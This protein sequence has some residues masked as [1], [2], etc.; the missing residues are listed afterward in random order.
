[1]R[2]CR[3][4][5]FYSTPATP[6][7]VDR[8]VAALVRELGGLPQGLQPRT[9][10][11]GGGTPS[12]L[13]PTHWNRIWE[14]LR[15]RRLLNAAEWTV[16][17]N[18]ATLSL[19]RARLL[20]SL[21]VNRVSL[22]AQSFDPSL[23][24]RLGRIHTRD[25]IFAS[26]DLLR[27]AGFENVNL[28]L[29]FA[30][31]GQ[32]RAAW[33]ATL[34]EAIALQPEHLSAY[35]VIYEENTPLSAQLAAGT[36][37]VDEDL[38]CD[39]YD[40]LLV[41]A[42]RHGFEQYEIANFAKRQAGDEA[43]EVPRRACAH[44]VNYWRGGPF[45]GLGPSATSYLDGVRTRNVADTVRYCERC[46]QGQSA[47]ESS[48]HLPP[49]A[50]AGETAAFG[51]RM[52]AGWPFAEFEQ[53][54]GFDLRDEWH[55]EIQELVGKDWGELRPDRFRLTRQGLRFADAAATLFLRPA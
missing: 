35:E 18:P 7:L 6:E 39:L 10:F 16:E 23:L 51:L 36:L 5:A 30:I 2:K 46:E 15:R 52:T 42:D 3:Y 12:L 32:T 4:C 9:V 53:V 11:F 33:R 17:C 47:V 50:R 26:F 1:M 24:D 13:N 49:L 45:H 54:T 14:T 28:D 8:Y 21:G 25:D 22:G 44:N 37:A 31:P 43:L 27:R 29:M 38:A 40:D 19:E 34:A 48:E 20:H 55:N 41:A